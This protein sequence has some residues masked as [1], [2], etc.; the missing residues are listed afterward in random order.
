[1][2]GS[3]VFEH[4]VFWFKRDFDFQ[5]TAAKQILRAQSVQAILVFVFD[6]VGQ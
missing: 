1:L 6:Q 2:C 4:F 3:Q 5:F